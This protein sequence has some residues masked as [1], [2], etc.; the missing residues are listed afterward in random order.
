MNDS[1]IV[2]N[3]KGEAVAFI[4]EDATRLWQANV[5][6][7]GLGLLAAGIRP[8][9]GWTRTSALAATSKYTGKKYKRT[10]INQARMDLRIWINNMKSALPTE[11]QS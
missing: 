6:H 3:T 11:I 9:R 10:E 1:R 7:S 2:Y 5:L 8:S 4:G